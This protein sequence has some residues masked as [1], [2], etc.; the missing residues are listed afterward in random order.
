M[1]IRLNTADATVPVLVREWKAGEKYSVLLW[2]IAEESDS[3]WGRE[4]VEF[5]PDE[6]T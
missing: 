4:A 1:E 2:E 6:I 5:A 3:R